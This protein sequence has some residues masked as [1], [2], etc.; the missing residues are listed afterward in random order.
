MLRALVISF[1]CA[2]LA[3]STVSLATVPVHDEDPHD[4]MRRLIESIE[5]RMRETDRLLSDAAA[6]GS[7]EHAE[8]G[9]LFDRSRESARKTVEDIDRLLEAAHHPHP[10]GGT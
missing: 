8:V 1:V 4:V 2:L 9:S 10:P 5:L 6:G 3:S 7:R